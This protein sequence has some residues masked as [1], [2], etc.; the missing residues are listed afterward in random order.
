[1]DLNFS[2]FNVL[3]GENNIGKTNI[4]MAIYKI[5][6]MKESPYR[7]NFSEEDFYLD[8]ST[9]E[10]AEKII[11]KLNFTEL[12]KNDFSAFCDH[13]NINSNSI[14]IMLEATWD[15][16]NNDAN[17]DIFFFREDDEKSSRGESFKLVDKEYI[18]FY[19][20]DAHRDIWKETQGSN[21]D[22][23]QIF[24]EY[25][26]NFLK[27][28]EIQIETI[29]TNLESYKESS[30]LSRE[31]DN[32]LIELKNK[33]IEF[34]V[35][36][37]LNELPP[38]LNNLKENFSII[39]QR[40]NIQNQLQELQSIVNGL[41]G[42]EE[43]K[44]LLKD[45]ILLFLPGAD[46]LELE[47][48]NIKET[49]LFDETKIQIENESILRQGTGLQNSFII[50]L[51]LSRLLT[52]IKFAENNINNLIIAI[53]EPE[54]HMHPHLQRN[55]IKKL[56]KKQ[57]EIRTEMGIN[58][59]IILTT[60]SPFILS[61]LDKSNICLVKKGEKS[62]EIKRL[63]NS[64]FQ[65]IHSDQLKHFESI[66]RMY[67][68]IFLARGVIIVEGQSE[69][70]AIPKFAENMENIDLDELG[71][72][73]IYAGGKGTSKVIYPILRRFT[74]CVAIRDK[75]KDGNSDE[76]LI[77]D[78]KEPYEK[79]DLL[80]FEHEIVNS[81]NNLSIIKKI[82]IQCNDEMSYVG[83]IRKYVPKTRNMNTNEIIESWETLELENLKSNINQEDLVTTLQKNG[84]N[85]LFW[86]NFCSD[87]PENEIPECYRKLIIKAK[88]LVI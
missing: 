37:D 61:Q 85:S 59:Q 35:N 10:R 18:P 49:D 1:M 55:F 29:K 65:G 4:L 73:L 26:T 51:K 83:L 15:E 72:T 3:V 63:D 13:I 58:V 31:L 44:S 60:H 12:E 80:D 67:P 81:V 9:G 5:L 2:D 20:I 50:A 45:N 82:L 24:K 33:N 34:I 79:T 16:S 39:K 36:W 86:S 77:N 53:E 7:V 71:L 27:P 6:K 40:V 62:V 76:K 17:V 70:G 52:N 66:F 46:D 14:S 78:E 48:G 19:Y 41:N 68:E 38:E 28:I 32:L 43:I 88:N 21:G 22:L 47:I 57:K 56:K 23:K 84:K 75:D 74:K 64:F 42:V 69:F 11:I 25:N 8:K 54:A 87:I 30:S